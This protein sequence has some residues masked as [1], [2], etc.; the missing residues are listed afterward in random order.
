MMLT[1]LAD[2]A[3]AA[4]LTVVEVGGWRT[5]GHGSF[6]SVE[7]VICHHTAGARTG[8]MPSLSVVTYGRRDLPG[9]LCN[10]GLGRDG[11]VYVVAA[12][13]AWHAGNTVNEALYG[14]NRSIGIEAENT[15]LGE[16]WNP[17]QVD[18]YARLCAAICKAYGLPASRVQGHKE[19]CSPRG[20]KPDPANLP[21]DMSGLRQQ[22]ISYIN[23]GTG[24]N[25]PKPPEVK[26][27]SYTLAPTPQGAGQHR[28]KVNIPPWDDISEAYVDFSVGYAPLNRA[29]I[30]IATRSGTFVNA[31][32]CS[33]N[34]VQIN[35]VYSNITMASDD[36]LRWGI[37]PGATSV[38]IDF[39]VS[40]PIAAPAIGLFC[41]EK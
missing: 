20:R 2:I 31:S 1:N 15:G 29:K 26:K 34:G 32:Y 6:R 9:P 30:Y 13:V 14:N 12:G 37:P 33:L 25:P 35:P 21:G 36:V 18:A 41:R 39:D 27:V 8:N 17:A 11:T 23:T 22:V 7:S 19:I 10:Y 24:T 3:R 28:V 40:S 38:S 5:R 4:G 16:A